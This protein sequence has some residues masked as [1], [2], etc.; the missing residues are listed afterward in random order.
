MPSAN[1]MGTGE[2]YTGTTVCRSRSKHDNIVK[3][4]Q[5]GS[6]TAISATEG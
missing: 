1:F 5:H 2:A 4:W 6:M 3:A